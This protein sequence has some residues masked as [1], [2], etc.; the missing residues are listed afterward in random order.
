MRDFIRL[1]IAAPLFCYAA[2]AHAQSPDERRTAADEL[3]NEGQQLLTAGQI[4]AACAKLEESQR[5]DP[6]LGRLLNVAY[7]HDQMHRTATAWSEYNE[8]AAMALQAHQPDREKFARGRA[9]ELAAKLSFVRLDPAAGADITEVTVD[10]RPVPREQWVVPF[11]IDPGAHT[12]SFGAPGH[13]AQTQAVTVPDTQTVRVVMGPLEPLPA[14]E[15]PAAAPPQPAPSP[16]APSPEPAPAP[17]D[18]Q[19]APAPSHT[20]RTIGWALGAVG[21]VGL[22]VGA[23]FALHALSLQHQADPLCPSK[24]CSQQ[25]MSLINDATTSANVGTAGFVVGVATLAA[26]TWLIIRS[27]SSPSAASSAPPAKAGAPRF[28]PYVAQDRGGLV[29]EGEW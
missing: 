7:C 29:V 27:L 2:V 28:A 16:V 9:A 4:P 19:P 21:V 18:V 12:L 22:G 23:G 1:T 24:R 14:S 3:F 11:P 8:A 17:I 20:M 15:T 26:G 6:K 25:G 13:R 10:G 5:Q